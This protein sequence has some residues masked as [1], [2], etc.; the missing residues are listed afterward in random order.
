MRRIQVWKGGG[1][2]SEIIV[3]RLVHVEV[4]YRCNILSVDSGT[5][6][7]RVWLR[8]LSVSISI[9]LSLTHTYT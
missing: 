7:M 6:W 8:I 9:S 4:M 1:S 5:N 3:F 2:Y